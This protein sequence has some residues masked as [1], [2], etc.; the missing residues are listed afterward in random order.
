[1]EPDLADL[2]PLFVGEVRGRL[3]RL[4]GFCPAVESDPEAA[5]EARRELH[6]L[7]GAGRMLRLGAFAELCH[8]AEGLLQG[9]RPNVVRLLTRV[10]DRLSA[11]VDS[12]AAGESP[13]PD[14][15]LLAALAAG[16]S[17][18]PVASAGVAAQPAPQQGTHEAPV[19]LASDEV[20]IDAAALNDLA[21]G[22][23]RLRILARGAERHVA[24][25]HDLA[26]LAEAS[27]REP[28]PQQTLAALGT[29][30]RRAEVEAEASQS[31]LQR[32]AET[33]LDALLALQLQPLHGL[34]L[35][36]ARHA[37]ELAR[38]LGREVETAVHGSETRLD[39]RITQELEEALVHIV[40]NA[41]D[42]GIETPETRASLGKKP[43]GMLRIE[44]VATANRVRIT[45]AD[46]GAGID[47]GRVVESAVAAGLIDPPRAAALSRDEALRL[48]FLPGFST[49]RE[50]TEVSGRGIGLD[51]VASIVARAGGFAT[52]ESHPGRGTSVVVEVPVARRGEEVTVVRAGAMRLA[53]PSS[54]VQRVDR[55][56]AADI[57]ERDG[58][59]LARVDGRLVPFVFLARALGEEPPAVQLLLRGAHAGRPVAVAVDAVEGSEEVLLHPLGPTLSGNPFL[60]SVALLASGQPIGVLSPD[61]LASH[62][63]APE[64]VTPAKRARPTRLRVLLVDDSLVT[65][66]MERRLLEDAGFDVG[67]A[68]DG[69]DALAQLSQERFDCLVTDVEMPGMDGYELTRHVRAIPALAHLPIVVVTTHDRPDERLKGLEAGA[70]A[71]LAKQGLDARELA[72]LVRRLG[73]S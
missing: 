5:A 3:E 36:L 55:L 19:A 39:R 17:G 40:R 49:R 72:A 43:A 2:I 6:T 4:V 56:R 42:H 60:D 48:L 13:H 8:A 50:V 65:R 24:R 67:V 45:I 22:A 54:V 10:T 14:P 62:A 47:P 59:A 16:P 26:R 63:D 18:P 37:R 52:I 9:S 38:S 30:L 64:T 12:V 58:R 35:A 51:A 34:L 7:K 66:E 53:L 69:H 33:Q 25:L 15:D 1:V 20:R 21:E 57:V 41:V 73:G 27:T 68:A 28:H 29:T 32:A 44:A 46:D 61:A 71:Y 70:D 11:M 31:R 23:A